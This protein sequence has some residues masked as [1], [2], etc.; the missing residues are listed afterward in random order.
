MTITT[1][2]KSICKTVDDEVEAELCEL[3]QLNSFVIVNQQ[4]PIFY[5]IL[6]N[7]VFE[8]R[9]NLICTTRITRLL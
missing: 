1:T 7:Q 6:F 4:L 9:I 5:Q 2:M 3:Q 8:Y